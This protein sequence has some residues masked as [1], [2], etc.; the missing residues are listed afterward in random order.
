MLYRGLFVRLFVFPSISELF[1][2]SYVVQQVMCF[3]SR[4]SSMRA[5]STSLSQ[6]DTAHT[7]C[8]D[9]LMDAL[10]LSPRTIPVKTLLDEIFSQ[11]H[12][13]SVIIFFICA[14]QVEAYQRDQ[15][16]DQQGFATLHRRRRLLRLVLLKIDSRSDVISLAN[17]LNTQ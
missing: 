9:S 6:L 11:V 8:L 2:R 1:D 13:L 10:F 12:Y 14:S 5:S 15:D 4:W 3:A 17:A 7:Q 16:N